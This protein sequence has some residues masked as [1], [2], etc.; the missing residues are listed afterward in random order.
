MIPTTRRRRSVLACLSAYALLGAA[1]ALAVGAY[2]GG[3]ALR[4][5]MA[6]L[7][8]SVIPAG[9]VLTSRAR[10][11][12][13]G[14]SGQEGAGCF[15]TQ[16]IRLGELATAG[17]PSGVLRD[18]AVPAVPTPMALA[19]RGGHLGSPFIAG[20]GLGYGQARVQPIDWDG[21]VL[22]MAIRVEEALGPGFY[23]HGHEC[24]LILSHAD[25]TQR[26]ELGGLLRSFPHDPM[27]AAMQACARMLDCAQMF[28][29]QQ[30]RQPW[31]RRPFRDDSSPTV[32]LARPRV[33]LR[34]F[35]L[36]MVFVDELGP[37]LQLPSLPFVEGHP[38]PDGPVRLA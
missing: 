4:V 14:G 25:C 37:V 16:T 18:V 3:A 7:V 34:D 38:E 27:Q 11:R 30:L 21:F 15:E 12:P 17:R 8:L 20:D 2:A 19:S 28:R 1:I 13:R 10:R 33:E 23:A 5:G 6:A 35:E 36:H 31:P 26:V 22:S 32:T 24:T 9:A 29:M